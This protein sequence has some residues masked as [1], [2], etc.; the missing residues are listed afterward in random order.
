[1]GRGYLVDKIKANLQVGDAD[2]SSSNPVPISGGGAAGSNGDA[3][4]V[5]VSA[6]TAVQ[7]PSNT[8]IRVYVQGLIDNT[9]AVAVGSSTVVAADAT[10]RGILIFPSQSQVFQVNNTNLLYVD[11]QVSAEGITFYFEAT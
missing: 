10:Q 9:K 11:S 6:G 8:C 3:R 4:L 7:F 1:M 5:T 2:V